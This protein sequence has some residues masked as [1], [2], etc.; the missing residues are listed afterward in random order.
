VLLLGGL[1]ACGDEADRPVADIVPRP[2]NRPGFGAAIGVQN[3]TYEY[4][5]P[6]GA[7]DALAVGE[8]LEIVP[9]TLT[10]TVGESI[11]IVNEDRRG[12]NVGPWY[13]GAYET[14]TQR[15]ATPGIYLGICTVHPSGEFILQVIDG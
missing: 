10:A 7:S 14:L 5:I 8:P 2:T 13:V 15:F 6:D 4:T 3:A 9:Q 11:Q 12:H 1:A